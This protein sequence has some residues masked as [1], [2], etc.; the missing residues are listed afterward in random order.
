MNP[1]ICFKFNFETDNPVI[2][3]GLLDHVVQKV[4]ALAK[5]DHPY[6]AIEL[7]LMKPG[8]DRKTACLTLHTHDS[9]I[10]EES[11]EH[12]WDRAID[13]VFNQVEATNRHAVKLD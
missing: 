11:R 2:A 4:K 3:G 9:V 12:D 5:E 1:N 6:R 13:M 10:R 8:E 7:S